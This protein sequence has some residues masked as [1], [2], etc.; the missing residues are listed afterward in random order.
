MI[1]QKQ[2]LQVLN[3]LFL[4]D[5]VFYTEVE[6]L[7]S[8]DKGETGKQRPFCVFLDEV[9]VIMVT[10][11]HYGNYHGNHGNHHGMIDCSITL[12]A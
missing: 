11:K 12:S 9:T 8:T 10:G 6:N 7:N 1:F 5:E 2:S 4:R 3:F